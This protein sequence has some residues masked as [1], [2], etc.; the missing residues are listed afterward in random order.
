MF[1]AISYDFQQ[2]NN[3][4]NEKS[5]NI[6]NQTESSIGRLNEVADVMQKHRD[7]L[8]EASNIV[9]AQSKTSETS[10]AQQQR[11]IS[12]SVSKIE[13]TKAELKREI[14]EL[15][16]AAAIIDEEAGS[17]IKRLKFQ[18]EQALKSSEDVVSKTKE[19]NTNLETQTSTFNDAASKTLLKVGE[20]EVVLNDQSKK[21]DNISQLISIRASNISGNSDSTGAEY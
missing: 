20:F 14:E 12:G 1:D 13:E 4:L 7:N 10:L 16:R 9:V 19:L 15:V 5:E 18:M 17:A 21:L 6:K 2:L 3:D 8:L 11:H